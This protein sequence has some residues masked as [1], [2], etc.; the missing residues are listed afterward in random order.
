[1]EHKAAIGDLTKERESWSYAKEKEAV[2]T[3]AND[4]AFA[5][6]ASEPSF[7]LDSAV[8]VIDGMTRSGVER[9]DR[10][11]EVT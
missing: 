9:S 2:S 4:G 8:V 3:R 10:N 5:I 1:V 6:G 7:A 11:N